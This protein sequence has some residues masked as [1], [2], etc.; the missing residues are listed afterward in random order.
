MNKRCRTV[1]TPEPLGRNIIELYLLGFTCLQLSQDFSLEAIN[2]A[3]KWRRSEAFLG[4]SGP[5]FHFSGRTT[6]IAW[7]RQ[8][9]IS[10]CAPGCWYI[11]PQ[12][13]VDQHSIQGAC[14]IYKKKDT[15]YI[16]PS[17]S[18]STNLY[19]C[20]WVDILETKRRTY[21]QFD[22]TVNNNSV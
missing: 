8:Q 17:I 19:N 2:F 21:S 1:E 9:Q 13:H 5:R 4:S 3:T 18:P 14:G 20:L 10:G 16:L 22:A 7:T 12:G 15:F 6:T 11:E